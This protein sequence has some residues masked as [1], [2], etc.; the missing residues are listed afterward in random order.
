MYGP[1]TRHY[2]TGCKIMCFNVIAHFTL[3]CFKKENSAVMFP[4]F[5]NA[6]E[7]SDGRKL[8]FGLSE[9]RYMQRY[10]HIRVPIK[11]PIG[12]NNTFSGVR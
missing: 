7:M 4:I 10:I 11:F 2:D 8:L 9:V 3:D 12:R 6:K 1:S 5:H